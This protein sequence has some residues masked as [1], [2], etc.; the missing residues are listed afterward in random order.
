[1]SLPRSVVEMSTED[2]RARRVD[3]DKF[4]GFS[5]IH[6]DFQLP[7][8]NSMDEKAYWEHIDEDGESAS[9]AASSKMGDEPAP[10]VD[11]PKKKRPPRKRKKKKNG[12]A[13]STATTPL[14]STVNTPV[15]SAANTPTP[16]ED[17]ELLTEKLQQLA[18]SESTPDFTPIKP[19]PTQPSNASSFID[20]AKET[21]SAASLVQTT[22]VVKQPPTP[23][24]EQWQTAGKSKTPNRSIRRAEGT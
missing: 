24:E 20:K 13:N 16:S 10:P 9:E 22:P 3:S 6:E 7:V 8:R 23:V 2:F 18:I 19:E 15:A 14:A 11:P 1:M 5:F 12:G 4:R 17:G 21:P